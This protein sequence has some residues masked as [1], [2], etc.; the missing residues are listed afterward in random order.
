M[1]HII[2]IMKWWSSALSFLGSPSLFRQHLA[3][4]LLACD[5]LY[6]IWIRI[7]WGVKWCL[8]FFNQ[9]KDG[10]D[11]VDYPFKCSWKGKERLP[12]ILGVFL[13]K[14]G[15]IRFTLWCDDVDGHSIVSKMV[16]EFFSRPYNNETRRV[17]L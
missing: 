4:I 10:K 11:M 13:R 1:H 9:M 16:T 2:I 12:F 7:M 15:L 3:V 14:D 5:L 17:C 8:V 6:I